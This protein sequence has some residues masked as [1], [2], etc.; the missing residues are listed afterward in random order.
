MLGTAVVSYQGHTLDFSKPFRR[1]TVVE[2]ILAHNPGVSA[3]ELSTLKRAQS[4][5]ASVLM[6]FDVLHISGGPRM[7]TVGNAI[8]MVQD[9][10]ASRLD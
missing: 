10:L 7:V 4:L 9:I 2:S 1:M 5:A 8:E 3:E 6:H